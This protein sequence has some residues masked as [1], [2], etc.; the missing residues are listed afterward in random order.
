MSI[1]L[2]RLYADYKRVSKLFEENPYIIVKS[3]VGSPPE[4]Y[5]IEYKIRGLEQKGKN[6]IEKNNH[7]VEIILTRDY[8]Q[9]SPQCRMLTPIFHPNIAPHAIC[10]GDHWAAGESLTDLIVRIGEMICFQSYNIQSPL[11]GEAAKWADENINC[12]P[13]DIVNLIPER[14]PEDIIVEKEEAELV[15]HRKKWNIEEKEQTKI[16]IESKEPWLENI[17]KTTTTEY[18]LNCGSYCGSLKIQECINGHHI[19]ADCIVECQNC[20]KTLCVLCSLD[21]CA[22]CEKITCSDC[23][24]TCPL[25]NQLVCKEHIIKCEICNCEGCSRCIKTDY[26]DNK[27]ICNECTFKIEKPAK[28]TYGEIQ[29][30]KVDETLD[31]ELFYKNIQRRMPVRYCK[32]CGSKAQHEYSQFCKMCGKILSD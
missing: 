30:K 14:R 26:Y 31:S 10:I 28:V 24:T 3:A 13:I 5:K 20:G 19:C 9:E 2:I 8:P 15:K 12:L 18:C 6:I 22:V 4:R 7:L 32:Y 29:S 27:R 1:R 11:N 17:K 23:K 16:R 21:K 25:C